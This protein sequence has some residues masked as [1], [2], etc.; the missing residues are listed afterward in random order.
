MQGESKAGRKLR[1]LAMMHREIQIR[2]R[3]EQP[4]CLILKLAASLAV[5]EMNERSQGQFIPLPEAA[6]A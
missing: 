1:G 6:S 4:S 5:S 3:E 2:R